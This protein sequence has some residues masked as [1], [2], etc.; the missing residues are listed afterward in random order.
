MLS[1]IAFDKIISEISSAMKEVQEKTSQ[2]HADKINLTFSS[3][4]VK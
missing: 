3:S 2:L 1:E 4:A